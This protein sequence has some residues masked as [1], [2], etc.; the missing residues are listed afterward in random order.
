[1]RRLWHRLRWGHR[2]A[3]VWGQPELC[4]LCQIKAFRDLFDA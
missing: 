2:W 3:P 1:M 4:H